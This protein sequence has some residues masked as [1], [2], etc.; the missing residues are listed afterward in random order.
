MVH[1]LVHSNSSIFSKVF[2]KTRSPMKLLYVDDFVD[3]TESSR[4]RKQ[5]LGVEVKP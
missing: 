1:F 4:F 3:I 5:I 2:N